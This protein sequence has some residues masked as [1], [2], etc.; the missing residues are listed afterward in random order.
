MLRIAIVEDEAPCA[1]QLKEYIERYG[2][3]K[4]RTFEVLRFSEGHRD[5]RRQSHPGTG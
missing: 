2:R 4:G 3:E 5:G 1:E